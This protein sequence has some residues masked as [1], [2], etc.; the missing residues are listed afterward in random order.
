MKKTPK[1]SI[2]IPCFN[3]EKYIEIAVKSVLNQTY[4]DFIL[5][6]VDDNSTDNTLNIVKKIKDPRIVIYKYN[7][8][9]GC[10]PNMNR[11]LKLPKSPYVKI[12][13][14]DDILSPDCLKDEVEI[15]DKY[16]SVSLVFCASNIINSNGK[17]I[18][19]R[20]LFSDDRMIKGDKL[21]KK[22]LTSAHNILGEPSGTMFRKNI[23]E[24]YN[25]SLNEN[26]KYMPDLEMWIKTLKYGDGFYINKKLFS[27]R[28]HKSSG[29]PKLIKRSLDEHL[30]LMREYGKK[31]NIP[32]VEFL[33]F[34]IKLVLFLF[35]KI[36]FV[37]IYAR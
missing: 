37:F 13:C 33:F 5:N 2:F 35:G 15:L 9:I 16:P 23:I 20:K 31:Y 30:K 19:Q 18:F 7:T 27:F 12:L 14:A 4:K 34:Y 11:C 17:I 22:I 26:Y 29:T 1:L 8:N 28:L 25:I 10:H 24:K 36:I 6:I 3:E 32:L 21:I